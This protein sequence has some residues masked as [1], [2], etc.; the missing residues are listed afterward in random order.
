MTQYKLTYFNLRGRAETARYIFA[1]AGISYEDNRIEFADWP[2]LKP[3][4]PFRK[5]PV[6]E[7]DGTFIHQSLAIAR[8]IAR[9]TGLDGKSSLEKA[10]VDALA[11]TINDLAS[12]FPWKEQDKEK[13]KQIIDNI[14]ANVAPDVLKDL[15][16][17]LGDRQWFVGES[18]TWVDFYWEIC[19][20]TLM[21]MSP[22]FA[23]SNPKL[24]ALK[25]RV[26]ALPAIAEWIQRRPQTA[27]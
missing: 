7:V 2:T 15:E 5:L 4:I 12:L 21:S 8:Y 22:S 23:Q 17:Y 19:I 14:F 3:K 10:Q 27:L 13:K 20:T 25:S 11:D 24:L 18:V 6:L 9:E 26:Q 16:E 1:F